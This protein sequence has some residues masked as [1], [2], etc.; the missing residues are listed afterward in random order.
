M[1]LPLAND[2]VRKNPVTSRREANAVTH[3][4]MAAIMNVEL[5]VMGPPIALISINIGACVANANGAYITC[6]CS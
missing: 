6:V 2:S 5:W 1:D 3:L 4:P